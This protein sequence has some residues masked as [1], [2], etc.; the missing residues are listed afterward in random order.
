M[1]RAAFIIIPVS[2]LCAFF[3]TAQ[4]DSPMPTPNV[5]YSFEYY[6]KSGNGT[7]DEAELSAY[8]LSTW[9]RRNDGYLAEDEWVSVTNG[10]YPP[11][12]LNAFRDF[13]Y[14]DNDGDE[15]LYFDEVEDMLTE[16]GIFSFWDE[17]ADRGVSKQEFAGAL[18]SI[19][20]EQGSAPRDLAEWEIFIK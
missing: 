10:G 18:Y 11:F 2:A 16:T 1:N 13:R 4:V 6:D 12:A 17:N 5:P 9:G 19:Y 7:L 3:L 15:R 20:S 8:V 14:W